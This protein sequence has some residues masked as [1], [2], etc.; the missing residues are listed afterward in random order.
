M[1]TCTSSGNLL[2]FSFSH[3]KN[4]VFLPGTDDFHFG[5]RFWHHGLCS[6]GQGKHFNI[7]STSG[8]SCP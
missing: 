1:K 5:D 7:I 2:R 8:P 3:N 6:E 4:L